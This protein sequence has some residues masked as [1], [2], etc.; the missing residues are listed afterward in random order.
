MGIEGY[1][2]QKYGSTSHACPGYDVR[3]FDPENNYTEAGSGQLGVLAIRL[4]LP[5]GALMTVYRDDQRYL[6]T[7]MRE[8]PGFY[9]TGDE[10][11]KDEQGDVFVMSRTD[12]VINVA[13]HRLSS[14]RIEEVLHLHHPSTSQSIY[15]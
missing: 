9:S 4:P 2:P 1:L 13:G 14:G 8:I 3:V 6:D 11:M 5:P 10:G 15:Q 12:D 7:Y